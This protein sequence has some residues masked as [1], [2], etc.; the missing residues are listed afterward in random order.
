MMQYIKTGAKSETGSGSSSGHILR[1]PHNPSHQTFTK[2]KSPLNDTYK[3]EDTP[4]RTNTGKSRGTQQ[5]GTSRFDTNLDA[6]P[7]SFFNTDT[8]ANTT[9]ETA[10]DIDSLDSSEASDEDDHA[11]VT[12]K[13][14]NELSGLYDY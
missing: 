9:G 2:D 4:Q 8:G 5:W 6:L 3:P 12:R 14:L 1:I 7:D 11:G 10:A 13:P